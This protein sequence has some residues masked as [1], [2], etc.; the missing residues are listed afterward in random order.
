[1]TPTSQDNSSYL[2]LGGGQHAYLM[3]SLAKK[4]GLRII[5]WVD[6]SAD[7]RF[8]ESEDFLHV[9][10]D[11]NYIDFAKKGVGLIPGIASHKL[12]KKRSGL[13]KA[14]VNPAHFS[15]NIVDERALISEDVQMG[16]GN[17]IIGNAFIQSFTRIGNW[18]II[19]SGSI[20]EHDSFIG[21]HVHVAPG[22]NICGGVKIGHGSFIGAGSTIIEGVTIGD[23]AVIGAGSL[24]LSDVP[25]GE[26][27]F[28]SPSSN[29]GKNY[30]RLA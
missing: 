8:M 5:G 28:G 14:L 22:V 10:D 12:W 23:Q 21:D 13:L 4:Q 16:A 24:V 27:H 26:V 15:P 11:S 6:M 18:S 9:V 20:V 25:A 3:N 30:D 17:Q 7:S 19:N 1:M 29:K 2:I